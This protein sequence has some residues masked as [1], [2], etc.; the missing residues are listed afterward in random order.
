MRDG[1]C[2]HATSDLAKVMFSIGSKIYE[3]NKNGQNFKVIFDQND[4][5]ISN[6]DYKF[7]FH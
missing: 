7:Y 5:D 2:Q 6:F 1:H 4:F 3:T